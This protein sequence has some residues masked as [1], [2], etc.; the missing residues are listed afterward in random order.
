MQHFDHRGRTYRLFKRSGDRRAPWQFQIK[1]AGKRYATS[2][3]TPVLDV[4]VTKAKM[5][6]DA[7]DKKELAQ[8][9]AILSPR[10]VQASLCSIGEVLRIFDSTVLDIGDKHRIGIHSCLGVVL[11][12]GTGTT[13][14]IEKLSTFCLNAD[15]ARQYF[16]SALVKAQAQSSQ[17]G[18]ARVKRSANSTWCQMACL[19][20]PKLLAAYQ[21][22]GLA[23]PDV[24]PFLAVFTE[25]KF[26]KCETTYNPP[27]D[28]I[29]RSTLH[30]WLRLVPAIGPYRVMDRN[31]FL[32]VGLELACGLRRGEVSQV[33]WGMMTERH[34]A[35]L[36]EGS[37]AVKNQSGRLCVTPI[38]PFWKL[39]Q[40]R[41]EREGWRGK[42]SELVLAGTATDLAEDIFRNIGAWLRALGWKTEKTNHALRAY[43]G[44]LVAMRFDVYRAQAWLRHRSVQTTQADYGHFVKNNVFRP[45]KVRIRWA[46]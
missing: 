32:A 21:R 13:G 9:R 20:R 11:R 2:T 10:N 1:R 16:E 46:R 35:P 6:L 37:M 38:D 34:G 15:T 5:L 43:S 39:L 31:L 19:L 8:V 7:A 44:A 41:I 17:E 4:A 25:E 23:L 36:L 33:T 22:A 18:A 30:A 45:E 12:A 3:K 27:S 28:N 26:G 42:P 40:G 29:V 24:G 14:D